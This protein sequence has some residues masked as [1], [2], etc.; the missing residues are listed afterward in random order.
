M[1]VWVI[2]HVDAVL[3]FAL[4]GVHGQAVDSVQSMNQA[5]DAALANPD[6]GLVLVTED[7]SNLASERMSRLKSRIEKLAE[8]FPDKVKIIA[9]NE[10]GSIF[11][12]VPISYVKV[13]PPRQVSD[14]FKQESAERLKNARAEKLKATAEEPFFE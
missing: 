9:R 6:L 3:G 13:N 7:C 2:G 8:K 12:H 10:D 4:V 14:E 5:L 1:K 11:A